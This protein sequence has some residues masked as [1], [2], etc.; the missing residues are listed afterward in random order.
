MVQNVANSPQ[1]PKKYGTVNRIGTTE[2][3]RVV[4][5]VIDPAGKL[6]GN[7]SVA[8][9]H[10]DVFE[11]SYN[12]LLENAPKLEKYSD[13]MDPVKVEKIKNRGKWIRAI[14]TCVG[15]GIPLIK[16]KGDGPKGTW[17]QIGL[18]AL[19][20]LA[21]FILGSIVS[22]KVTTPPGAKEF[23]EATQAISKLD[24]QPM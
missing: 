2:N 21:G 24:I 18:T 14:F 12:Q 6:T 9:N 16:V 3:G 10:A 5:Q 11:K 22:V 15:G 13:S 8:S 19:G 1:T 23:A 7:L 20:T 17:K 4:Y